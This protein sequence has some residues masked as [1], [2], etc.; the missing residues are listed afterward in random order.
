MSATNRTRRYELHCHLDG[1]V[2]LETLTA[3]AVEQDRAL[4]AHP[5]RL[6]VAPAD[7]GSLHAFLPYVDIAI[8]LLQT[9]QALQ[10]VAA[11]LVEDWH[12]DD[13]VYG[14]VRFAPQ[15]HTRAGLSIDDAIAAV[16]DGLAQGAAATGV[17]TGM[18]LCCLRHQHPAVSMSVA[19][20]AVRRRDI[21][22]GL[23]LAGDERYPGAV[24]SEA[25]DLAHAAGLPVTVHAG[26]A[27]GP[28]SVWEALDVLGARRIGHGVRS[29]AERALLDRLHR[30]QITLETCPRCNVLTRAV[31][32]LADH[33][34][35]RLLR[36]GLRV[37]VS[38]DTRTTA[39][40]TLGQE[41]AALEATFGW[42]AA[43]EQRCQDNAAH[44]AFN[45]PGPSQRSSF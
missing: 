22:A 13:V 43:E 23:D 6:A 3:L 33:P 15:L 25:F 45:A 27:A 20:A 7:V 39:D 42:T 24:H 21:V 41:F 4:P 35:D 34:A 44:G 30:D 31:P 5:R 9:P 2:R 16:G 40:T 1:S 26:E 38:T 28:D 37:T 12:H 11:E 32:T 8:D 29:T 18:L 36:A 10:R 14:E 17:H 19:D